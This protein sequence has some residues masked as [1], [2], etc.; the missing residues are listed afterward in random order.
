M[1]R[2]AQLESARTS[3]D[4][5]GPHFSKP[6][7]CLSPSLET[8]PRQRPAQAVSS[9]FCLSINH[10]GF[11]E[12]AGWVGFSY[13]Q[14]KSLSLCSWWPGDPWMTRLAMAACHKAS[15]AWDPG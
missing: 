8:P 6:R 1:C 14:P 9:E 12:P 3:L 2:R 4:K 5:A 11:P 13:L 7:P 10:L 15:T